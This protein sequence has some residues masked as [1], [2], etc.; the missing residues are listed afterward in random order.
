[1]TL[2]NGT[3]QNQCFEPSD[4]GEL[5]TGWWMLTSALQL[6]EGQNWLKVTEESES[7]FKLILDL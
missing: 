5:F 6:L 2:I 1:M 7:R 3:G 4:F